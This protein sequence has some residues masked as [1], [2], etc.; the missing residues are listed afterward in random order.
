MGI[1][2]LPIVA[3]IDEGG[4]PRAASEGRRA[5]SIGDGVGVDEI[6]RGSSQRF[7]IDGSLAGRRVEREIIS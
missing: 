7:G 3:K 2:M 4:L 1:N 6:V 5:T